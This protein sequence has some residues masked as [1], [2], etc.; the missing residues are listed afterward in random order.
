MAGHNG[1]PYATSRSRSSA[2]RCGP[3]DPAVDATTRSTSTSTT[4][5][6]TRRSARAVR[7]LLPPGRQLLQLP[8]R[9]GAPL[10]PVAVADRGLRRRRRRRL[11][12][13]HRQ[14][15]HVNGA[16][17]QENIHI[18]L[19][20][21]GHTFGLDDFYDWTPTGRLLPHEGRQR[22]PDHRVRQVDAARLLAA[23]EEPLRALTQAGARMT[24]PLG[25]LP[26]LPKPRTDEA[27][28][29]PEGI[30]VP[31]VRRRL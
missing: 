27:R 17:N 21:I 24:P 3:H 9:R 23:P 4:S 31:L 6:R 2:G 11:G 7:P 10:R 22:H 29:V 1:W 15:V 5:G 25:R 28:G 13:A 26:R 30:T 14:R 18:L 12:P 19:H 16:L 20:E 8:R